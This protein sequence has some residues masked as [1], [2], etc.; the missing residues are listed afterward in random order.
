MEV[1]PIYLLKS[2]AILSLFYSCYTLLLKN[3]TY[4]TAN[5]FFLLIGIVASFFIPLIKIKNIIWVES[6]RVS[7]ITNAPK[8]IANLAEVQETMVTSIATPFNW[9]LL[10][11]SFYGIGVL[12]FLTRFSVQFWSVRKIVKSKEV[13]KTDNFSI[14]ETDH[15]IAPF[16][17]FNTIVYNKNMYTNDELAVIITHEKV[18]CTQYH[19]IDIIF[20]HI[21]IALQWFNPFAWLFLKAIQQNLE[22]LA[23][24]A[25]IHQNISISSYQNVLL[26]AITI[27]VQ[28]NTI[29]N[30]FYQSLIK[31]RIIMLHKQSKSKQHWKLLTILP[32]VITFIFSCNTET[33]TKEKETSFHNQ[34]YYI[35]VL[36]S[37]DSPG[38]TSPI[39]VKKNKLPKIS[40][41][42][43]MR[44]H[45][46][47]KTKKI[48]KGVDFKAP[49]G[50]PVYATS[51]GAVT[52]AGKETGYGNIIKIKHPAGY[53]TRYAQLRDIHV[54]IGDKVS[55]NQHIGGVGSS[56]TS[57]G[58][59]LHYEIL[60]D[61]KHVNPK[62]FLGYFTEYNI[63]NKIT[64]ELLQTTVSLFN[65]NY[66]DVKI[67]IDHVK[68]TN[69]GYISQL[70][71]SSK[72][73][74]NIHYT[75]NFTIDKENLLIEPFKFY[76]D[77][78]EKELNI[79]H[80]NNSR[81]LISKNMEKVVI[82]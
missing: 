1:I 8:R 81:M 62:A 37:E 6:L 53:E 82:D 69:E 23:D 52:F 50:T 80:A 47:L 77:Q 22:F 15:N 59:H 41:E 38:F 4:F 21:L 16:S 13:K 63:S 73:K 24:A 40:S 33:I 79:I 19:T 36:G 27:Q 54:T 2:A 48:H 42:F 17:F 46:M 9:L 76:Y 11:L 66:S 49:F 34:S 61:N 5:R 20:S 44:I 28:S 43:G 55:I 72:F 39:S 10:I 57:S 25:T 26:R 78:K 35:E 3:E 65:A 68:R 51:A 75:L 71:F 64:K 56:G 14:V 32:L 70:S 29:T 7:Q 60:K 18:H 45:P 58:P 12:F 30:N 67:K 74:E 31:K